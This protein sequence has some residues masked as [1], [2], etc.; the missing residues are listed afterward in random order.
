MVG[1][2][3]GK[4]ALVTGAA[5]G[6]GKATATLMAAEGAKVLLAD[7]NE[8]AGCAVAEAIGPNAAFTKLDVTAEE[9]WKAAVEFAVSRFGSL[10]ILVNNAG[11]SPHD[12]I[13]DGTLAGW[14]LIHSVNVES[15]FLGCHTAIP[16]MVRSGG[17]SIVNMSSIAGMRGVADYASYGSAKAGVRNLTKSVALYC[18]QERYNIRCNSVHP[19]SIDT[20]ILDADKAKHGPAAITMREKAIPM[21]RLGRPG[22]VAYAVVFLASDE[23]SYITGAELVVDGGKTV[24]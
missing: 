17:G 10:T 23:A 2:L 21:H 24:R 20:P 3:E 4:V 13:E 19:G 6:L 7:I 16:A 22:E 15:V 11:I 12:T 8:A 5:S 9:Q 18:A 1:R 14:R